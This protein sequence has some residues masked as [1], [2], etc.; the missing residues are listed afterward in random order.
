M[1]RR[2]V[3]LWLWLRLTTRF[4]D[5]LFQQTDQREPRQA[6]L[7]RG[8][9]LISGGGFERGHHRIP[10]D[11]RDALTNIES[12]LDWRVPR[13]LFA[14]SIREVME[15]DLATAGKYDGPLDDIAKLAH[16][17][18]PVERLQCLEGARVDC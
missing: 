16:V 11:F 4:E 17:A 8:L 9:C 3:G 18:G 1:H 5:V 14:K 12:S 15:L 13:R 7:A 2:R 6:K 10:F